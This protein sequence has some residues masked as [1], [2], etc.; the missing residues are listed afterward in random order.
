MWERV[1]RWVREK[2]TTTHIKSLKVTVAARQKLSSRSPMLLL[3]WASP[4][5]HFL[6]L[7]V[8]DSKQSSSKFWWKLETTQ[9]RKGGWGVV[10]LILSI[11]LGAP[12]PT[13]SLTLAFSWFLLNKREERE[14]FRNSSSRIKLNL[15]HWSW[16]G[17]RWGL[18]HA[19]AHLNSCDKLRGSLNL[20]VKDWEIKFH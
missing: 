2:A 11:F 12:T 10:L 20:P 15:H 18:C 17:D 6:L 4:I 9:K 14:S 8:G 7:C 16:H 13:V 3:T 19:H 1:S 5:R